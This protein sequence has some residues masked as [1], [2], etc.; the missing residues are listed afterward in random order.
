MRHPIAALALTA[1]ALVLTGCSGFQ[2]SAIAPTRAALTGVKG[3]IHGG[4]NPIGYASLQVYAAGTNSGYGSGATPLIPAGSYYAGGASGCVASGTQV[5]YPGVVSDANGNFGLTGDYT[6]TLGTNLYITATGGNPGGGTNNSSVLMVGFGLCDNLANVTFL[7]VNEITTVGTVWALAQFMRDSYSASAQTGS[8]NI[9]APSTNVTG[10][11]QAFADINTLINYQT[12]YTPG[13]AAGSGAIVPAGTTIPVQEILAIADSLAACVNTTGA[14]PCTML[15][16][17]TTVNG[18]APSDIVGAALNIANNP[19]VNANSILQLRSS[20]AP[21]VTNFIAANDLTLA[22]TYTG[23]GINAPSALAVDATGNL[24]IANSA[25]NSVTE[26]AHNGTNVGSSPF[27]A[28]AISAP[29]ALAID[30]NGNAWIANSGNSTLT[31][32]TSAGT[33]ASSSPFTD[34]GLSTPT[35]VAI[36]GRGNIW[37]ANS[38]NNS[39]SEFSSSGTAL[40][41]TTGYTATGLAA[42]VSIAINPH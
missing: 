12:G 14:G 18:V 32:L 15:F 34:G 9:G 23:N 30:T 25:G 19:A 22:V 41:G 2:P 37:V 40:S 1:A 35:S 42:P 4:Q 26:L 28:G 17:Y 8:I 7:Q 38:G 21:W 24:W 16:G 3:N 11:N 39:A 33:N 29:A 31:E 13:P 10:L 27:T 5:C 6:C 20:Q 36:D